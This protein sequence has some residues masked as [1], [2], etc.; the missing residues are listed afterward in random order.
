VGFFP[1]LTISVEGTLNQFARVL[2]EWVQQ[3]LDLLDSANV[4]YAREYKKA[5]IT[6]EI[7]LTLF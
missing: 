2:K 1:L 7:F 6:E 5:L 4:K 3:L